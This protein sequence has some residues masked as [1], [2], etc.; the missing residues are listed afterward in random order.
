VAVPPGPPLNAVWPSA[1]AQ[2][3]SNVSRGGRRRAQIDAR[4]L[5]NTRTISPPSGPIAPSL[6]GNPEWSSL[7]PLR[8]CR[9]APIRN[10]PKFHLIRRDREI[11]SGQRRRV[12]GDSV[13][14]TSSC[15]IRG[16]RHIIFVEGQNCLNLFVAAPL[17]PANWLQ[18]ETQTVNPSCPYFSLHGSSALIGGV[19]PIWRRR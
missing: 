14:F 3:V 2:P 15:R 5:V 12:D 10:L 18:V 11:F 7:E 19:R 6:L 17:W 4:H 1:R 16:K 13:R 8:S 9:R